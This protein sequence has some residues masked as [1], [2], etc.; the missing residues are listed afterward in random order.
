LINIFFKKEDKNLLQQLV[1]CILQSLADP[2]V[3]L[4]ALRGLGNIVAVGSEEANKYAPTVLDALMS[5]IDDS[6]EV[7]A[8]EAMNG[9]AKVFAIV[10]E[11]IYF[12]FLLL[13][14]LLKYNI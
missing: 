10:D 2:T 9:L 1:N 14:N 13:F 5:S 3:K 6:N 4:P 8:M 11:V 12:N 7:I